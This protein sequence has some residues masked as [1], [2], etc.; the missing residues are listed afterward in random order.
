MS[1]AGATLIER[2]RQAPAA[3]CAARRS[4]YVR[5]A[6]S[7]PD[8]GHGRGGRM[9]GAHECANVQPRRRPHGAHAPPPRRTGTQ[10]A[11]TH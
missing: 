2:R 3:A 11:S 5:F 6:A 4:A 8:T 1:R 10:C 9:R 7:C